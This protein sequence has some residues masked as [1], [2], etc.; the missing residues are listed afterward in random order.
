[1]EAKLAVE[2]LAIQLAHLKFSSH[3]RTRPTTTIFGPQNKRP[4]RTLPAAALAAVVAAAAAVAGFVGL[5]GLCALGFLWPQRVRIEY[6]N[7]IESK[8]RAEQSGIRM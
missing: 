5:S 8:R 2:L 3:T 6:W 4:N 1:M 7:R